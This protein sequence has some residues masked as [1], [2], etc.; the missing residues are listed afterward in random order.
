MK[1]LII[2]GKPSHEDY[3]QFTDK[4]YVITFTGRASQF[5]PYYADTDTVIMAAR[6]IN[7]KLIE[8]YVKNTKANAKN[9]IQT[10]EE[11]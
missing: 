3:K 10:E 9:P 4:G 7:K 6:P 2:N 11:K 8:Q 1:Y 5:H